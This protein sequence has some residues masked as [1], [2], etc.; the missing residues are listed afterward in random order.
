MAI[1]LLRLQINKIINYLAEQ[2]EKIIRE[3][4]RTK[5]TKNRTLN[6]QDAYGWAVYYAGKEVR[7]GYF[8]AAPQAK[9]MRNG[10]VSKGIIPGYGREDVE[11]YLN[12]YQPKSKNF[13]LLVVNAVFYT[14]ILEQGRGGVMRKY[15]VISQEFKDLTDVG[16][17]VSKNFT[18][19]FT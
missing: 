13:Y 18:V 6:Q 16:R 9:K 12:E 4:V 15:R 1:N 8:T 2:G 5:T 17:K 14:P 3:A 19:N 7:R 11:E 10:W